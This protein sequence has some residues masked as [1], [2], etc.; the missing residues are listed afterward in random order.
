MIMSFWRTLFARRAAPERPD[1]RL[2]EMQA[3][4]LARRAVTGTRPLHVTE[5]VRTERGVEWR[6]GT[7]SVGSGVTLRIDDATGEILERRDWGVR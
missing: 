4:E 5:V 7:G 2:T 1:C 6:I 3:L